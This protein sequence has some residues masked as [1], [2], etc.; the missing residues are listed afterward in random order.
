MSKL[1]YDQAEIKWNYATFYFDKLSRENL[2]F[3]QWKVHGQDVKWLDSLPATE[4]KIQ[5]EPSLLQMLCNF[6]LNLEWVKDLS[7]LNNTKNQTY[8]FGEA[9][10]HGQRIHK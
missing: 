3:Q 4:K 6:C 5:H 1:G 8:Y 9:R 7:R 10:S 2:W